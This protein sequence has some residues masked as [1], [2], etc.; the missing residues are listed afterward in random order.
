MVDF[1][2]GD[3][4]PEIGCIFGRSFETEMDIPA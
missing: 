4:K 2:V 1:G 3:D